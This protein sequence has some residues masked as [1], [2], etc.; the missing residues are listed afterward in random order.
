MKRLLE[1]TALSLALLPLIM[2]VF[3]LRKMRAPKTSMNFARPVSILIPARNE[4][5]TISGAITSALGSTGISVELIVLD[6]HSTDG[7][8]NIARAIS[9]PRLRVISSRSLPPG[10]G[11]KN[12]A[13]AQLAEAARHD[14]LLFLDAD[15]RL[16]PDGVAR[17]MSRLDAEQDLAMLSG[18]PRQITVTWLEWMLLPFIHVLLLGYLPFAFDRGTDPRLAAACGQLIM[19][20]A[21]A[22]HASG[23]HDAIRGHLHDGIAL[24]RSLRRAGFRTSLIDATTLATCRMYH[25]TRDVWDGLSKNATEGMATPR[26]LPVWTFLLGVAHVLPFLFPSSTTIWAARIS[27]LSFRGLLAFCFHQKWTTAIFSPVA[28]TIL[29]ALQWKALIDRIRGQPAKWR[30]RIYSKSDLS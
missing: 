16:Q 27:S 7:T 11:G 17:L 15:V 8:A 2:S 18:V 10:W 23:G 1:K 28:T 25:N 22:Y 12:H 26:G 13:C 4:A 5:A 3:N 19:V 6:D 29:L 14:I 20:R 21:D 30:G 9:D 24:A